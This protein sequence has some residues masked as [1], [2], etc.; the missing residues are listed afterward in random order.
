MAGIRERCR[1]PDKSVLQTFSVIKCP[2]NDV[3]ARLHD[4]MAVILRHEGCDRVAPKPVQLADL[5]A[6][7]RRDDTAARH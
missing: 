7:Y 1:L 5:L 6:P 2:A 4:R 3:I